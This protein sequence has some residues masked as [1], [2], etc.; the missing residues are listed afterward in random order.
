MPQNWK[1]Y[2]IGEVVSY[3]NGGAWAASCYSDSGVP[4][5]RVSDVNNGN[6]DLS[7]CK[8]LDLNYAEKY[9]KHILLKND[10]I[11]CT[12]G[13][14]P[15]QQSSVVGGVG[16]VS[17]DVEGAYLNQNAVLIRSI[18]FEI[19]DQRWLGYLAK[20]SI[21]KQHIE[22]EARGSAN[23]VR[24]AIS[25]L[26]LLEFQLPPLPEQRAIAAILSSL[27][28][29]IEL[30]LQMNKTLEEMTM[31]LYKHWFVDFGPF[32]DGK[33]IDS[34]LGPIPE[35]WEVKSL[36]DV[37]DV[38]SSK[39]IFLKEYVEDGIPFY[40]GKEIIQLSKGANIST[41][42]FITKERYNEIKDKFGV[43]LKYDIL[44]SSVGTIGVSWLVEHDQPFYFKDGNLT[45]IKNYSDRVNGTFI[46]QWLKSRETQDQ[47]KSS[48]IG[49]TQ[50][51]LT[52]S[53]LRTLKL[54]LPPVDFSYIN[55]VSEKF[56]LWN[57]LFVTN[58]R[59]IETLTALR[60]TLL[61]KLISGE[62]RVKEAEQTLSE[63][64]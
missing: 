3:V 46:S 18:D 15:D 54:A 26:L 39:R 29:K 28:D 47:I 14:H 16:I 22:S 4:V 55:E 61:P 41:E 38:G 23:Q 43:P 25:N 45:W 8:Y 21:F 57:E 34:E 40:R 62:V 36:G 31:T 20:S 24:I 7:A 11:V 44:I 52:I 19:I 56:I 27:D 50:Q 9:K 51:A 17:N 35:G 13:S 33:F 32:K 60:D 48:T 30:N 10:V 59:E 5:V 53:A 42:L 37:T 58:K 64:L 49:S 6:V 1:T 63:V 12:V 2:K